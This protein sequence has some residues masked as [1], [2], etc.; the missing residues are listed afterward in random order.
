MLGNGV[1]L[2][3]LEDLGPFDS[4]HDGGDLRDLTGDHFLKL[5]TTMK[6]LN[7][8]LHF[9][10]AS[11]SIG[12]SSHAGGGAAMWAGERGF[13][14]VGRSRTAGLHPQR[15]GE[16]RHGARGAIIRPRPL[17]HRRAPSPSAPL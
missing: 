8:R 1:V 6:E 11:T 12:S 3:M 2:R 7:L 14:W 16:A 5:F 13:A 9:S 4:I 15:A 10:Y 17:R